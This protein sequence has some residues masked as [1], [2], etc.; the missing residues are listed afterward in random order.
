MAIQETIFS[1]KRY[2]VLKKEIE[3]SQVTDQEI[4][5]SAGKKL[6]AYIHEHNLEIAGPWSVLYFKWDMPNNKAV[7][8]IAFPI[9]NLSEVTDPEFSIVDVP[10]HKAS[11]DTL[12]GA[13]SGLKDIHQG[14]MSYIAE[15]ELN[16]E[17][18]P[19]MAIEE[20]LVDPMKDPNPESWITNTYYLHN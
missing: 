3:I 20:Y 13:Y 19:V 1:P 10:E 6:G 9:S 2:L 8:G 16:T 17:N 11:M 15:K 4:Y 18:V 5:D 7:L 12:H 14:L